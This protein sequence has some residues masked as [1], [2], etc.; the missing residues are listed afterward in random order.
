MYLKKKINKEKTLHNVPVLALLARGI[1]IV[2]ALDQ[3]KCCAA[4]DDRQFA[5]QGQL[6]F[7]VRGFQLHRMG[8]AV[9]FRSGALGM[10]ADRAYGLCAG[11]GEVGIEACVLSEHLGGCAAAHPSQVTDEE[12][13]LVSHGGAPV[14]DVVVTPGQT[15]ASRQRG[16]KAGIKRLHGQRFLRRYLR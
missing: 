12:H 15:P 3:P 8:Q 6:D 1:K 9:E 5:A 7:H 14:Q 13:A 10:L 11:S 16:D 2:L 4:L